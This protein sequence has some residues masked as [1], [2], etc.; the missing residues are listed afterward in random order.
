MP[1]FPFTFE[2]GTPAAD[3]PAPRSRMSAEPSII[4]VH[5]YEPPAA[6][7]ERAAALPPGMAI[8]DGTPDLFQA[9]RDV[10]GEQPAGRVVFTPGPW[11]GKPPGMAWE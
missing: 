8:E 7:A 4:I 10:A 9:V 5:R 2:D 3:E 6:A 1:R 11:I